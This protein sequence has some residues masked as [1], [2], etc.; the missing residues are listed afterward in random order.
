[1]P[2]FGH[3]SD[4]ES[5]QSLTAA[6]SYDHQIALVDR[7]RQDDDNGG[8]QSVHDN[9]NQSLPGLPGAPISQKSTRQS[10]REELARRRYARWQEDRSAD[11]GQPES[12]ASAG[13]YEGADRPSDTSA[14]EPGKGRD[15]SR[16]QRGKQRVHG[17]WHR[18]KASPRPADTGAE[19]DILYEN[20][21]GA[22]FF[23]IPLFSRQSLLNF[24][25]AP[26]LT[27]ALRPS[28]VDITNAQV[29]D[30]S[31]EWAWR[32]WYVD[33]S[34]DVD[35][36]GW[37]YSF[38]FQRGF[39]WHGTHPWFHSFVRRRRWL[40]KRVRRRGHAGQNGQEARALHML[41]ADYFTIH[42]RRDRSPTSRPASTVGSGFGARAEDEHPEPAHE[43][44]DIPTLMA[45]LRKAAIDREKVVAVRR[46]IDQG[47]E[48]LYYLADQVRP[49]PPA[50]TPFPAHPLTSP[51]I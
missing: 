30:P 13:Q 7:T 18:N 42:S 37:Q 44:R 32:S 4:I 15:T 17:T 14:P 10:L 43:M 12:S 48:E 33:M 3:H 51:P 46:F 38:S 26:W 35:E 40:R 20:Q 2:I 8:V 45:A 25:P 39:S 5:E 31:W 50:N 23:G 16:L 11:T 49:A 9:G 41:N 28:P 36:E 29:P 19:I 21:R 22:F 27:R 34:H 1:M 24:D 47:G 6:A